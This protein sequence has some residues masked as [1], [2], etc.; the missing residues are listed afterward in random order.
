MIVS[1]RQTV[2]RESVWDFCP[3]YTGVRLHFV[4]PLCVGSFPLEQTSVL[5]SSSLSK[6]CTFFVRFYLLPLVRW[7][8]GR[9]L[10]PRS[11]AWEYA[12]QANRAKRFGRPCAR[13]R[14][15]TGNSDTGNLYTPCPR[16][17]G[18]ALKA[19]INLLLLACKNG[20]Q[21]SGERLVALEDRLS[22]VGFVTCAWLN[23]G[24][25]MWQ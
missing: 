25:F 23:G 4:L 19:T 13:D 20:I 15:E 2:Q 6:R 24:F 1:S 14:L 16:S 18:R 22:L 21:L 5:A 8:G 17:V 12:T 11:S 7:D 3:G 9:W 10:Q